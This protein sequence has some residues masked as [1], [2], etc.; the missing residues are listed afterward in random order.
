M[1]PPALKI[2]GADES[3]TRWLSNNKRCT[4]CKHLTIL[5]NNHCCHFCKVPSCSCFTDGQN[6]TYDDFWYGDDE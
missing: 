2:S 1:N 5:H 4:K 3:E 6:D